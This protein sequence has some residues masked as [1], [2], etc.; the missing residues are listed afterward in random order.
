MMEDVRNCKNNSDVNFSGVT[1]ILI[2]TVTIRLK[3]N[4]KIAIVGEIVIIEKIAVLKE[5]VVVEKSQ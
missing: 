2:S 1:G 5:I 3:S 4:L